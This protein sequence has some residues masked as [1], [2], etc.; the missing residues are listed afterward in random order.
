MSEIEIT[1]DGSATIYIPQIDEHYHSTK[2]ALSESIHV[3]RNCAYDHH[4]IIDDEDDTLTVLEVGLGT[5][6]N[7]AL[8]AMVA[9]DMK[10][11]HYIALELNPLEREFID[12]LNYG[13]LVDKKIFDAIHDAPWEVPTP[14]T[15]YFTI[16]KRK[17]DYT[18]CKLPQGI[19][20]VYFDAF[21]PEKQP[22][23]WTEERFR[24]LFNSMARFSVL[25]TYCAKGVVRRRLERVGFE[26][27][28]IP[29]PPNGKREILRAKK[30]Y[31]YLPR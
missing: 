20:V 26:V 12:Q 23:M 14:I 17:A 24:D 18:T 25:T 3:Y 6:L 16:E 5:G 22:E 19:N 8:T 2:G 27:E 13:S 9:D 31:N 1:D 21:A 11:V 28:R 30:G 29:G 10:P 15:P 7:A 4:P